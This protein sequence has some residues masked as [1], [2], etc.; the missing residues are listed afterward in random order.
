MGEGVGHS[1][2]EVS[3]CM[4]VYS[5]F[6]EVKMAEFCAFSSAPCFFL[7]LITS[8]ASVFGGAA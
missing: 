4:H 1:L 6:I 8:T 5:C 7:S 2:L 3:A